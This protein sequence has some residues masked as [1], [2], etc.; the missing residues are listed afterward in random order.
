MMNITIEICLTEICLTEICL[1]EKFINSTLLSSYECGAH[2]YPILPNDVI[3]GVVDKFHLFTPF[4]CQV[5][6]NPFCRV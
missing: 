5:V 3:W 1:A 2:I 4:R 6:S